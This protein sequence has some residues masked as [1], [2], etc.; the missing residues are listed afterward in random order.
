M[1]K[2]IVFA[3][4]FA[5]ATG[6]SA[7]SDVQT[8]ISGDIEHGGFGGPVVKISEIGDQSAIFIGGRGGWIINHALVI[9][10]GGYGMVSEVN[11]AANTVVEMG[12]GGLEVGGIL[13][14]NSLLHIAG[15]VLIGGGGVTEH[16][17]DIFDPEPEEWETYPFFVL[18]PG[19]DLELN[20]TSFMRLTGGVSYRYISGLDLPVYM[21]NDFPQSDDFSGMSFVIGMKFGKF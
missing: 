13:G 2:L 14:S 1:R 3:A 15:Q 8:L 21:E 11:T 5:L 9:G 10:A 7:Q 6:L 16:D 4:V 18:E 19:V 20:V 17:Q 12:Y